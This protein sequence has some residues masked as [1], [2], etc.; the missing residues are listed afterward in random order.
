MQILRESD[1]T[2]SKCSDS[3][4][5]CHPLDNTSS[6]ASIAERAGVIVEIVSKRK[7]NTSRRS[8]ILEATKLCNS[9][10]Q[11]KFV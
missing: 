6:E 7:E 1:L 5:E 9:R 2:E 4:I 3:D 11:C 10:S 8:I